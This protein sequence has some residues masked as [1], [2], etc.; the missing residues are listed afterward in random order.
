M[1]RAHEIK[2]IWNGVGRSYEPE[3]ARTLRRLI[4]PPNANPGREY[5][6]TFIT[7][8]G[9]QGESGGPGCVRLWELSD[10]VT[11]EHSTVV[12]SPKLVARPDI[13]CL[14]G[15]YSLIDSFV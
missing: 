3:V 6:V 11:R 12:T 9:P 1:Q 7:L 8:I 14:L 5:V 15:I 4:S 2:V 10:W 13:T